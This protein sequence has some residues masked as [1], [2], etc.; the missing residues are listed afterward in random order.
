MKRTIAVCLFAFCT[1]ACE[2]P[3]SDQAVNF[4]FITADDLEW[5][6][7][8]FELEIYTSNLNTNTIKWY[9]KTIL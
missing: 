1:S 8:S 2:V 3:E 6:S 5:S 7:G 9:I 4:L